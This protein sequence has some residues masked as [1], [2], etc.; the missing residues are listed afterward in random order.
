MKYVIAA[1]S[2]I[3][4]FILFVSLAYSGDTQKPLI[5]QSG[6]TPTI[7]PVKPETSTPQFP[8]PVI[9]GPTIQITSPGV[10]E[11]VA[12]GSPY[13]IRWSK[14]GQMSQ[15]VTIALMK[16]NVTVEIGRNVPNNGLYEWLPSSDK[17]GPGKFQLRIITSDNK[18]Y[19]DSAIFQ[20]I[21]PFIKITDPNL[22]DGIKAQD[23]NKQKMRDKIK[24]L[25]EWITDE[26]G[27]TSGETQSNDIDN[28][29]I[30]SGRIERK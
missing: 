24:S 16:D 4:S 30:S 8:R 6:T 19:S 9:P 11:Q 7:S 2:L 18:I 23:T 29:T 26:M 20:L 12:I 5:P 22:T 1:F 15:F 13:K 10:N 21:K 27:E 28:A 3:L 17:F 25:N 14:I